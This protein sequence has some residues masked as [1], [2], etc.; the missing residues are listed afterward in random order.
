MNEFDHETLPPP[1]ESRTDPAPAPTATDLVFVQELLLKIDERL[2]K[3]TSDAN[4]IA[5][6]IF[7]RLG[8]L[9]EGQRDLLSKVEDAVEVGGRL[10]VRVEKLAG[11]YET[12]ADEFLVLDN[13]T[14]VRAGET[15]AHVARMPSFHGEEDD[16]K[17]RAAGESSGE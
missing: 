2:D 10:A 16:E 13:R 1:A 14:S 5:A 8:D 9:E 17:A 3:I 7:G 15:A 11:I 4:Q 12:L 6:A